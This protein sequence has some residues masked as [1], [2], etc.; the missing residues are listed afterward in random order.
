MQDVTP[1]PV[2]PTT[3]VPPGTVVPARAGRRSMLSTSEGASSAAFGATDWLLLATAS[4]IW[5]SSFLLIAI[6]LDSFAPTV[7]TWLRMVFGFAALVLIPAAR[8]PIDR[9]DLP[10]LA[11]VG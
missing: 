6:G 9:A 11:V 1:P 2:E 10:R 3:T 4:G 5:G 8:T 7:I